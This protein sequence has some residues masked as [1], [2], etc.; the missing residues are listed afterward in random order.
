MDVLPLALG[1]SGSLAFPH[2]LLLL[3]WLMAGGA[4]RRAICVLTDNHFDQSSLTL[5]AQGNLLSIIEI[6]P[7]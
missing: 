7:A 5:P 4:Y 6:M 3:E 1:H 2:V